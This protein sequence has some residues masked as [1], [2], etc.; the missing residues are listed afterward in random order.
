M[1]GVARDGGVV[2]LICGVR[3]GVGSGLEVGEE[4]F[5]SVVV[6]L[7]KLVLEVMMGEMPAGIDSSAGGV[8]RDSLSLQ[9]TI[10]I[11]KISK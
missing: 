7:G 3:E 6:L 2:E 10:R 9:A 8:D 5:A 11:Q 4:R 1:E